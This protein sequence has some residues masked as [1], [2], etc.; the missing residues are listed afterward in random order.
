MDLSFIAEV[1]VSVEDAHQILKT[2]RLEHESADED[3]ISG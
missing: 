2:V 1:G 3:T